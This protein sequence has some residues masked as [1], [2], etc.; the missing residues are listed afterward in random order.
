[1]DNRSFDFGVMGQ[2]KG[3]VSSNFGRGHCAY[4]WKSALWIRFCRQ[5]TTCHSLR[6][7]ILLPCFGPRSHHNLKGE[8]FCVPRLQLPHLM[9]MLTK[10]TPKA[11]QNTPAAPAASRPTKS[12]QWQTAIAAAP[13]TS[14][15]EQAAQRHARSPAISVDIPASQRFKAKRKL[16][17]ERRDV[18]VAVAAMGWSTVR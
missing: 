9:D 12:V 4:I 14:P 13:S 8:F 18:P 16:A 1:M 10:M 17:R 15:L 6:R 11:A 5:G 7:S 2:S 3:R